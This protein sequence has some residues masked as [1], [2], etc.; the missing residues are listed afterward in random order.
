[1]ERKDLEMPRPVRPQSSDPTDAVN[2]IIDVYCGAVGSLALKESEPSDE[3]T[4]QFQF[5]SVSKCPQHLSLW[6]A[7]RAHTFK[8]TRQLGLS[9]CLRLRQQVKTS[10]RH[11]PRNR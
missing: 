11:L 10:F 2:A 1:M 3:D 4:A 7:F 9:Q 5:P 8:Q 6:S